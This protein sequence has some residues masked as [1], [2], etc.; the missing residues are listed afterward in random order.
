LTVPTPF[1]SYFAL[2]EATVSVDRL[3]TY[4][5]SSD[6]DNLDAAARY[7]WNMALCEALYPVL[8]VQEIALRNAL[9][10]GISRLHGVMWFD[11]PGLLDSYAQ[12]SVASVKSDL[13][14]DRKP[15]TP[16]HIVARLTFGFWTSLFNRAY[17]RPLWQP[18]LRQPTPFAYAGPLRTRNDL[19]VRM[20]S[21]RRFRNRIFHHEPIWY[22]ATLVQDHADI[23]E[24]IGWIDPIFRRTVD[25]IDR[26]PTVH[27]QGPAHYRSIITTFC[28]NERLAP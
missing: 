5:L 6:Q 24:A 17:E 20:N 25:A 22:R 9:H 10:D 3:S 15:I 18:L 19:S 12:N 27:Q 16:G 21:I 13:R 7:L 8:Q 28:A 23:L 2:L 26:F 14:R 1:Q 11:T 4:R